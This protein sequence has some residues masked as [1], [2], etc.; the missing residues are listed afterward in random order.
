MSKAITKACVGGAIA[1][2][3][4]LGAVAPAGADPSSYGA[5]HSQFGNLTCNCQP[6]APLSGPA[7]TQELNRGI[8]GGFAG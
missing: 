6:Q 3:A 5:D 1:L 8:R 4:W 2:A 7:L